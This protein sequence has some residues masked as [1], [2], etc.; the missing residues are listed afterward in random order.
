MEVGGSERNALTS[1]LATQMQEPYVSI[2]KAPYLTQL[3]M[4][5]LLQVQTRGS[6]LKCETR[7]LW[8]KYKAC[9]ISQ[10]ESRA[11]LGN[12]SMGHFSAN[13]I[14]PIVC[15]LKWG[16][17]THKRINASSDMLDLLSGSNLLITA[18]TTGSSMLKPERSMMKQ[19]V[20]E[21]EGDKIHQRLNEELSSRHDKN[22]HQAIHPNTSTRITSN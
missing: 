4:N 5:M 6:W 20:W 11:A 17:K 13:L 19:E 3:F 12:D 10:N 21:I 16:Q 8:L 22:I 7:G 2:V 15:P 14:P 1:V 9:G 18:L